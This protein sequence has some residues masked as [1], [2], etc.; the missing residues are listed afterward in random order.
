MNP[1][2]SASTVPVQ[3]PFVTRW[4]ALAP[5]VVLGLAGFALGYAASAPETAATDNQLTVLLRFMALT[6]LAMAF[7]FALLIDW[8]LRDPAS[9]GLVVAYFMAL[10][11]MAIVPGL[12][13]AEVYLMPAALTFHIGMLLTLVAG[14][15]DGQLRRRT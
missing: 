6:K 15:Q 12:I 7:G 14:L 9:G 2:P 3:V 13:W 8:R 5:A 10:S 11:V 4:L 1:I